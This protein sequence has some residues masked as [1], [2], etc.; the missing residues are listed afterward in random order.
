M[1]IG[2]FMLFYLLLD[3]KMSENKVVQALITF[4]YYQ[5]IK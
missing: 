1:L 2:V 3:V 5:A 4:I